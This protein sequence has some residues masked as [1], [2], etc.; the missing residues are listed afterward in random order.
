MGL[1][2]NKNNFYLRGGPWREPA[3]P[4]AGRQAPCRPAGGRQALSTRKIT[5]VS[6]LMWF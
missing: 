1:Y 6:H 3:A 4:P 2:V 5:S